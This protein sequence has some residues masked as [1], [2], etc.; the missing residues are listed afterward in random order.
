M[1]V[2]NASIVVVLGA[3]NDDSGALS[4]LAQQ[5]GMLAARLYHQLVTR[6]ACQI[7]CTGGF[8][9]HFNCSSTA[10]WQIQQR[11]LT[12]LG[13]KPEHL[14][15]G[16]DSRFTFEDAALSKEKLNG[17]PLPDLH[18]VTSGFHLSRAALI[19]DSLFSQHSRTYHGAITPVSCEQYQQLLAHEHSVRNREYAN[20]K[21]YKQQRGV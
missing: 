6:Q 4:A 11:H 10:H 7:L 2:T 21:A 15:V 1:T 8:G 9:A 19:F 20:I 16:V 13:V 17:F 5:R 14:L 18:I 3:P 12:T